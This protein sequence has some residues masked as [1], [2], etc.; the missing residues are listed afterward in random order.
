MRFSQSPEAHNSQLDPKRTDIDDAI[1]A[2]K[3][4]L[5]VCGYKKE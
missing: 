5:A 4:S 3:E 2:L 1:E